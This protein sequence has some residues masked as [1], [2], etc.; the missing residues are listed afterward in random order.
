MVDA[1]VM[2]NGEEEHDEYVGAQILGALWLPE[3]S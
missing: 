1:L 2:D 3:R